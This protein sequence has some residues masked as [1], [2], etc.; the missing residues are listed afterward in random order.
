MTDKALVNTKKPRSM[1]KARVKFMVR[2]LPAY[3]KVQCC[4]TLLG[5]NKR[6]DVSL[7]RKMLTD[8]VSFATHPPRG[9]GRRGEDNCTNERHVH[10]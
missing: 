8:F 3:K 4:Y 2:P 9:V 10:E 5:K 7:K 1:V 6:Q